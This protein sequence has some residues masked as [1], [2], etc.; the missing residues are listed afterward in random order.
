M[1]PA[2][3][4]LVPLAEQ[5]SLLWTR[6]TLFADDLLRPRNL[7][8]LLILAFVA[9]A[10][11]GLRHVLAARMTE[12]MRGLTHR[13]KWQLRALVILRNRLG[14]IS[15]AALAW[16]AYLV[17]FETMRWP[18]QYRL[19]QLAAT[20]GTAWVV[21]AFLTRLVRNP[22]LRRIVAWGLWIWVTLFYLGLL[23]ETEAALDG[24]AVQM[25]GIRISVWS[26][27][28]AF[29]LIL[30]L[31]AAARF[32]STASAARVTRNEDLSPSMRVLVVK[33]LQIVLYAGAFF[34][35]LK[36]VGVDLTGLA[37]LSGAIGVGLGFG[38]QKVISNL[39][40]GVIIL[41]DKSIKP[42]D[43]ISIGDTFGWVTTLT[44][45]YVSITTRDGKEYLIPNEDLITGQVVNWS[46]SNDLVRLDIFFGTA[47]GDDPHLVRRTAI[48]AAKGVGRVLSAKAP[49]CHIVGFGDSSV[50][51]ILRFWIAD[52]TEGL[53]NIRGNVYL[54]LWDAFQAEG[55]SIPFPQREVRML[56]GDGDAG[57]R[58]EGGSRVS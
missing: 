7:W 9:L 48:A 53:T 52:P 28:S 43:V 51:Y 40:S 38:L 19:L 17:A 18:T 44:A 35:G 37:V 26:A 4:D 57:E 50:D 47:Y 33:M 23:D 54:A 56:G 58:A 11:L 45:R 15:F 3:Q 2:L 30:V 8:Q 49:V 31:F 29:A 25:G 34:L 55:I 41:L 13:P 36:A 16:V 22:F 6:A 39:V 5:L 1:D 14:L 10:A 12:W 32:V 27:I 24:L 20:I 21:V 46:H 42:G